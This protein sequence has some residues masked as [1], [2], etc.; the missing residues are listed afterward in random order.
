MTFGSYLRQRRESLR[1]EDRR[2]SVRQVAQRIGVEPAYLSK[3]E[4]CDVAPPSEEKVRAL[5]LELGEDPDV[6]LAMA[7]KVS[8]DLL[9]T[10]RKRPALFADLIRQLKSAPDQAV[11]RIVREVR[12]GD[13]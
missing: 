7:G 8:S 13:W 4:R 11:L 3:I 12:D 6:L 5:A 2:F 9:E 10:I 1:Q